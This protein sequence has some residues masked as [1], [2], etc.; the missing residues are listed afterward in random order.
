VS[1]IRDSLARVGVLPPDRAAP[2]AELFDDEVDAAVRAFQQQRGLTVDGKVGPD[3]YSALQAAR[4]KLG[5]RKLYDSHGHPY[6]GDDVADLQRQLL[7]MGFDLGRQDGIYGPRTAAAVAAFQRESGLK[8]DGQCGYETLLAL[9][10]ARPRSTAGNPHELREDLALRRRGVGLA[11]KAIVIDAGHGGDDTGWLVGEVCERDIAFDV[12]TRLQGRL[13][14][15]GATAELT[16]GP[17]TAPDDA[18]RAAFAN[19]TD[20]DL[21]I[22][23]HCDGA[24]SSRCHGV[25]TYYFGTGPE[26]DSRAGARLAGLIQREI[27]ARVPALL[28]ARTH[29]K[30]WGLLRLTRMP[31]VRVELGYLTHAGDAALLAEPEVRDGIAE[32]VLAAVQRMFLPIDVDHPTGTFRLA[33]LAVS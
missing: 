27:V 31:A 21:L 14:A 32:A 24:P 4:R 25:A 9:R 13:Q 6:T 23:L 26:R 19:A 15:A 29:A 33:D 28:D 20:A 7:D 5:D 18:T 16:R 30:T 1:D 3:T 11:G 8:P 22:S 2:D 17:D 10:N 12:A